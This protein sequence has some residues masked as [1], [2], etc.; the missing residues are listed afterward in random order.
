MNSIE[1]QF[2]TLDSSLDSRYNSENKTQQFTT[3]LARSLH[4]DCKIKV[5]IT[6]IEYPVH[7]S[8]QDD[9]DL[10]DTRF[11]VSCSLT[12]NRTHLTGSGIT[13]PGPFNTPVYTDSI[14]AFVPDPPKSTSQS[15][16][17]RRAYLEWWY[18]DPGPGRYV[19][20][21]GLTVKDVKGNLIRFHSDKPLRVGLRISTAL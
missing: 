8:Y 13:H 14:Y 16:A 17:L 15:V 2:I 9:S 21:I 12:T 19:D 10:H 20:T 1:S 18:I 3:P 11:F 7:W 5:A 6:F 4:I